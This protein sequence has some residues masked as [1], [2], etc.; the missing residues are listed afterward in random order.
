MDVLFL[1][2][3]NSQED[4]LPSLEREEES[5]YRLLAP[6]ALQQQFMLHRESYANIS[7]IHEYLVLFRNNLSVFLY[8]GH[9]GKDK[10][11]LDDTHALSA[12]I[13]QALGQCSQLK[14]VVLNGC[15]TK[16]Q[17]Q[18]LLKQGVP[19]VIAT[20]AAINDELAT[21]FS[22]RFFQALKEQANYGEAFELAVAE[23]LTQK[24]IT[25][26][27]DITFDLTED[28]EIKDDN[29]PIWGIFYKEENKAVLDEK[30]P[31]KIQVPTPEEYT[32][33]EKLINGLIDAL[34]D[35][36]NDVEM[37]QMKMMKG[38]KVK[39]SRK[40]MTILN[41]LPAPIADHLRKLMVPVDDENEG[42]DKISLA[43]LQQL[44]LTYNT[45]MDLL[46]F[47][48]LAQLWETKAKNP[49]TIII[50]ET[51]KKTI[52][53]FIKMEQ[54][55][56]DQLVY[57]PLIVLLGETLEKLNVDYF[58]EELAELKESLAT[59]QTFQDACLFMELLRKKLREESIANY[60]I[61]DLCIR[62]E[63]SLTVI[64]HQLGF[65]A[66]YTL[67][68]VNKIDIQKY[69]H[70]QK[71]TFK[72]SMVLLLD[73][74]GGLEAEETILDRYTDNR[75]VLL[76]K[77]EDDE[78][79]DE[80]NLSPF[81]IDSNAFEKNTDVSRLYFY[82]YS[83]TDSFWFKYVFKLNDPPLDCSD[84]KYQI[85]KDQLV[86]FEQLLSPS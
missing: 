73:L 60:E 58:V 48:L 86:A 47:T 50:P 37:I 5:V 75:S 36:N 41:S 78:I 76:L 39:L 23:T 7:K 61:T 33:N 67:A 29:E 18:E 1:A 54:K 72:H 66:K 22:I 83:Q 28:S 11:L 42:Y 3:S 43:R 24:A 71:A 35:Y 74:L 2:F 44:V 6:R 14:M 64:F 49:D 65:I 31:T 40:R 55:G 10:L 81:I 84:K 25:V 26:H 20:S 85:V 51:E 59:E 17:V 15:S 68:A 34:V 12:G 32:P 4:R 38:K 52:R 80:I 56:R 27:R 30:L 21:N 8:S 9:A 62:G 46:V 69:R 77:M 79:I 19:L 82:A 57:L 63:E 53:E 16:G 45:T 70:Q 13:A